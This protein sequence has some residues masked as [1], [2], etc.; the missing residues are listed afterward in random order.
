MNHIVMNYIG[1]LLMNHFNLLIKL[2]YFIIFYNIF[3]FIIRYTTTLCSTCSI[4]RTLIN[5]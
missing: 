4:Y 2:L 1:L 5:Y 3:N